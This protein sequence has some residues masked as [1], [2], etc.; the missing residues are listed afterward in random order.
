MKN[1]SQVF[2]WR[3]SDAGRPATMHLND[4][5][6]IWTCPPNAEDEV[7]IQL[8]LDNKTLSMYDPET[9]EE[10]MRA[11]CNT[12]LILR[13]DSR[14]IPVIQFIIET[15]EEQGFNVIFNP[16]FL[17]YLDEMLYNKGFRTPKELV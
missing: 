12:I 16:E 9:G 1:T 11:N 2:G 17:Y 4:A 6:C 13:I 5:L 8:Y 10:L 7:L 14:T 3:V 15:A